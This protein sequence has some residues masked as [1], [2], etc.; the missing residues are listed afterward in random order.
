MR[1]SI[2]VFMILLLSLFL[3]PQFI[4]AAETDGDDKPVKTK[5]VEKD[6]MIM[7]EFWIKGKL[8][9]RIPQGKSQEAFDA[10]VQNWSKRLN[11]IFSG[12]TQIKDIRSGISG[13]NGIVFRGREQM[14]IIDP[15]SAKLMKTTP[16]KMAEI[17]AT[18]IRFALRVPPGFALK[19]KNIIIP[20]NESVTIGF[21]GSFEGEFSF[22]GYDPNLI[23]ISSS[24]QK[25]II[26]VRGVNCG[27]GLFKV[28][29][30][31]REDSVYF[32]VQEKAGNAP[33]SIKLEVSG[34]PADADFIKQALHSIIYMLS[35]AKSG[36]W[37]NIG[38]PLN[39][40]KF[41]NL[42]AGEFQS[43]ILPVKVD[44]E[45]YL[46][47]A[48]NAK[49]FIQNIGFKWEKPTVL[50][51]SNKP[52][53]IRQD[54]ELFSGRFSLKTPVR[55]FYHHMNANEQP[56]RNLY[57]SIENTGNIPA[58]VFVSP[59]GAGPSSDELFVGHQA[60]M[61]YFDNE[62]EEKGYFVTL[63]PG[64][65]FL[66]ERR[67]VKNKQTV[68]GLGYL[69]M[70]AGSELKLSVYSSVIPGKSPQAGAEPTPEKPWVKTSRGV[71]PAVI[72][73]EPTHEIGGKYTFIYVGG[74][75]YSQDVNTGDP[76]YGNYGAIYDINL[77]IENKLN[78]DRD[79]WIYYVP[80]GGV[81][82]GIF[83]IDGKIV[84][85][86]LANPAQKVLLKK[87]TVRTGGSEK[88]RLQT[89]PQ[90]GAFYPVKIVVE[91]EYVKK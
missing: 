62:R 75:P 4:A 13:S 82:R 53:I 56:W 6:N 28:K 35:N 80:G 37:T 20:L 69:Y 70:T 14:L 81:S 72:P 73:L 29:A 88:V 23:S 60:A 90:G 65:R 61:S 36:A 84:E 71:F 9:G 52:E 5:I 7:A 25:N 57:I 38:E 54:G 68:S 15:E 77:T 46:M 83:D 1:K 59:V 34:K 86:P 16:G 32:K 45:D 78:E 63:K 51:V 64:A 39:K 17:W 10:R 89:M 12:K 21:T 33:D 40:G 74:E 58:R 91:S 67:L 44:G 19:D 76:N 85:T 49:V 2:P 31:D 41:K 3:A 47:S 18:G 43:L 24:K 11:D 8:L 42:S 87:L 66:L 26:V 50:M 48:A 79:A 27:K 30:A 22:S 55:Y